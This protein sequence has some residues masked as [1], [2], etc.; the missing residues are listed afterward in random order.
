MV[1]EGKLEW[2]PNW[3]WETI[4][5]TNKTG[6]AVSYSTQYDKVI[7]SVSD[8]KIIEVK[9]YTYRNNTWSRVSISGRINRYASKSTFNTEEE[10]LTF[11]KETFYLQFPNSQMSY[12][13]TP[14]TIREV[15]RLLSKK[16]V[17]STL[18]I[19][20]LSY[21]FNRDPSKQIEIVEVQCQNGILS[22]PYKRYGDTEDNWELVLEKC[23]KKYHSFISLFK[24]IFKV[25]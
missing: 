5:T 20:K 16:P 25:G 12:W 24:S 22:I 10:L 13:G 3:S 4:S 6:N 11:L 7:L 9:A 19:Y 1:G 21:Y 15:I 2:L 14:P 18:K 23:S 17:V 8:S